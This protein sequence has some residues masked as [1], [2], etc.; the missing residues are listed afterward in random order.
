MAALQATLG[1]TTLS[2]DSTFAV[3]MVGLFVPEQFDV[4]LTPFTDCGCHQGLRVQIS[5]VKLL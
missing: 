3:H 4:A 5:Q 2:S 1:L